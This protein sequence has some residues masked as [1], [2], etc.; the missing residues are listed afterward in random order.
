ME[1]PEAEERRR[2]LERY[3]RQVLR[4]SNQQHRIALTILG[5]A[6]EMKPLRS[7]PQN[8]G[9]TMSTLS[10]ALHTAADDFRAFVAEVE[11][12]FGHKPPPHIVTAIETVKAQAKAVDPTQPAATVPAPAPATEPAKLA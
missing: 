8:K 1:L 12:L 11:R 6:H 9:D 7:D 3:A 5:L 4:L 2:D 10:N